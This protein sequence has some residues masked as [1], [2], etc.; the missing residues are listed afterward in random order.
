[1]SQS[2]SAR[3]TPE[4]VPGR[5]NAGRADQP[6]STVDPRGPDARARRQDRRLLSSVGA[7]LPDG[8]VPAAASDPLPRRA[9]MER[10]LAGPHGQEL[11]RRGVL[12]ARAEVCES[13]GGSCLSDRKSIAPSR[14][15]GDTLR[16]APSN[17]QIFSLRGT[18]RPEL[19]PAAPPAQREEGIALRLPCR[20]PPCTSKGS[21][22]LSHRDWSTPVE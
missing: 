4:T 9:G 12:A 14:H 17:P 18:E 11:V 15:H 2:T 10:R 8:A 22:I 13:R 1:M 20:G 19:A 5:C 3:F 21:W 6:R 16:R 7:V